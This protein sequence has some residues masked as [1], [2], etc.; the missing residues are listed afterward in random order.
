MVVQYV[1]PRK[2]MEDQIGIQ[3]Q[4][5]FMTLKSCHDNTC[6]VHYSALTYVYSASHIQV[7]QRLIGMVFLL[8][9]LVG[10]VSMYVLYF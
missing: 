8:L 6:T 10:Y 1:K 3:K 7:L 2:E 9:A 4:P 5:L